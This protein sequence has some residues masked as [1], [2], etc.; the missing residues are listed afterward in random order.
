MERTIQRKSMAS[1]ARIPK[2]SRTIGAATFES[3]S[4]IM[5]TTKKTPQMSAL[6]HA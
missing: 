5:M 3:E 1:T 2:S 6:C 4:A